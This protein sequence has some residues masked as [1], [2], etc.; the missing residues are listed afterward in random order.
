MAEIKKITY[1]GKIGV[2]G[3]ATHNPEMIDVH[4]DRQLPGYLTD[5]LW[6][7]W[8]EEGT[9]VRVTIEVLDE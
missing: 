9:K 5:Q 1:E 7:L 8:S 2:T 3:R 4:D 6:E